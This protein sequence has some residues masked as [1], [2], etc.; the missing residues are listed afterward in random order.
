M[1]WRTSQVMKSSVIAR[2]IALYDFV[3]AIKKRDVDALKAIKY[4]GERFYEM[5]KFIILL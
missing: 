1:G 4:Q 5:K 2:S 3:Q